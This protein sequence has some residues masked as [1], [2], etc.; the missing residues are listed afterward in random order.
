MN[1]DEKKTIFKKLNKKGF[2]PQHVAEVGVYFPQT[3]NI[4]DYA[5]QGTRTTFV[6]PNPDSIQRIK[7][8]FEG[9]EN[10]TLHEVAV[11]D[12]NASVKLVQRE[13]S[14]FL[15]IVDNSPAIV[16]DLYQVNQADIFEVDAVTFDKIDD[17]TI[18]LISIDVEGSEWYVLQNLISRPA[19]IS[20]E[21]HG[22][23]YKN[24]NLERIINWMRDHDYN[25]WYKDRS[26]SIFVKNG[27]FD[28]NLCDRLAYALHEI[29]LCFR[30]F[31]KILHRKFMS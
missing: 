20:L 21:T 18:D 27:V 4:Y 25:I 16:N 13:A 7:Q 19:V 15:S 10:I 26:D 22:G 29:Y 17:G 6:E 9:C 14:T 3:S 30:T 12:R 24:P 31:K 23:L 1:F 5:L 28:I 8:H 11:F 2:K